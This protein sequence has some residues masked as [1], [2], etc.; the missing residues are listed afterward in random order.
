MLYR[1][2]GRAPWRAPRKSTAESDTPFRN[3]VLLSA[4]LSVQ[5]P[6]KSNS[7]LVTH[8]PE[9]KLLPTART[10]LRI[11][12]QS[13]FGGLHPRR[14]TFPHRLRRLRTT[15]FSSFLA[16]IQLKC[17]SWFQVKFIAL[18]STWCGYTRKMAPKGARA[19]GAGGVQPVAARGARRTGIHGCSRDGLPPSRR[20]AR[21]IARVHCTLR[22]G[23]SRPALGSTAA[24]VA[25]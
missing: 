13:R 17:A 9:I 14:M 20:S 19:P 16:A 4:W 3:D 5:R 8:D 12:P 2:I 24:R 25:R 11:L 18:Q 15:P 1:G 6:A 7:D 10:R 21:A 23:P 22:A